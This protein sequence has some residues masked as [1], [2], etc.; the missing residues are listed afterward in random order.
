MYIVVVVVYLLCS[1]FQRT[2]ATRQSKRQESSYSYT[3]KDGWIHASFICLFFTSI[4]P[5]QQ[6]NCATVTLGWFLHG[7]RPLF[8][9]LRHIYKI[10]RIYAII[11]IYIIKYMRKGYTS[12]DTIQANANIPPSG[13]IYIKIY[14][15]YNR[16]SVIY[17]VYN[18]CAQYVSL[19]SF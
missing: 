9:S 3:Y 18:V 17:R 11:C 2:A 6:E 14:C 13:Y 5:Q 15:G 7:S 12:R 4:S 19:L 8:S 1:L 16:Q 10:F